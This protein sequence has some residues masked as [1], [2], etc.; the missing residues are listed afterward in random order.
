MKKNLLTALT[1]GSLTLGLS[2][3]TGCESSTT[4]APA[5]VVSTATVRTGNIHNLSTQSGANAASLTWS[6]SVFA[7]ANRMLLVAVTKRALVDLGSVTYGGAPLTKLG[8]SDAGT[9]N[10]PHAEIWYLLSPPVGTADIVA[11][12]SSGIEFWQVAALDITGIDQTTPFGTPM[13]AAKSTANPGVTAA[14]LGNDLVLDVVAY[15]SH[16]DTV[17]AGPGQF[18]LWSGSCDGNWKGAVSTEAGAASVDMTWALPAGNW[19][20]IAVALKPAP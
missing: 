9:G 15:E 10:N 17:V 1:L 4:A 7:G 8:A 13:R 16:T 20:Q 6:H 5:P 2:L 12:L 11:T 14:A 18:R 19:A 3:L